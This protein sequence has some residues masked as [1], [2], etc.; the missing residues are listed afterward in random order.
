MIKNVLEMQGHAFSQSRVRP[1]SHELSA[2]GPFLIRL[3]L[4]SKLP[5]RIFF[6][7]RNEGLT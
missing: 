1:A 2:S 6:T 3:I 4:V 7:C 5:D